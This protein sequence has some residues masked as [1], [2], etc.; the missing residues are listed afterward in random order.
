MN[1]LTTGEAAER[2]GVPQTTLKNWINHLAI[3]TS[4]DSRGRRRIHD[5]V[6][7]VLEAV[8]DMRGEDCGYQTIRRRIG[9]LTDGQPS[10]TVGGQLPTD[11]RPPGDGQQA[12]EALNIP[13]DALV[14]QIVTAIQE[15]NDL[16]EKYARATYEIGELRERVKGRDEKLAELQGRLE[17]QARKIEL[18]EAPKRPW[19]RFW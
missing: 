6:L 7:P 11:T 12:T 14:S 5:D 13:S 18:L 8:K 19:W 15:N 1:G 17:E 3:P 4:T 10:L 16:A 9:P 2:L